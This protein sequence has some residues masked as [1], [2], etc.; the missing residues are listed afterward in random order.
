VSRSV[1]EEVNAKPCVISGREVE[2]EILHALQQSYVSPVPKSL[3]SIVAAW[4]APV[5]S[6]KRGSILANNF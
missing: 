6:T 2:P 3:K 1:F 4:A 5:G